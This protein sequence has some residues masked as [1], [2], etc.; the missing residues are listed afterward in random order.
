MKTGEYAIVILLAV[1][2]SL[3]IT[4]PIIFTRPNTIEYIAKV[5]NEDGLAAQ[6]MRNSKSKKAR[7]ASLAMSELG[8]HANISWT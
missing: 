5:N 2:I 4:L 8:G 7:S 1:L 3:I 6:T